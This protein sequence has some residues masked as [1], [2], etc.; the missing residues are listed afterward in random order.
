M[1]NIPMTN[2][3]TVLIPSFTVEKKTRALRPGIWG[4]AGLISMFAVTIGVFALHLMIVSVFKITS[5]FFSDNAAIVF[6][7]L[8]MIFGLVFGVLAYLSF[9]PAYRQHISYSLTK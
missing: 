1:T 3:C 2:N 7:V 6:P 5:T 4:F 8:T 9:Y